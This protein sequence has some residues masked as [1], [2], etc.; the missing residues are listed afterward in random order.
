[1][2]TRLGKRIAH[3]MENALLARDRVEMR[4]MEA[5]LSLI[6]APRRKLAPKRKRRSRSR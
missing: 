5:L 2:A 3:T 1:M 6:E 4:A